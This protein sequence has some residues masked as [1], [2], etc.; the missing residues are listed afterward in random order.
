MPFQI[1]IANL[2][3]SVLYDVKY[4]VVKVCFAFSL[5][6]A[7]WPIRGEKRVP[8]NDSLWVLF[9]CCSVL[10][11]LVSWGALPLVM[12]Y[13]R[14]LCKFPFWNQS[15][16][17]SFLT[18]RQ[19]VCVMLKWAPNEKKGLDKYW[20]TWANVSNPSPR[21]VSSSSSLICPFHFGIPAAADIWQINRQLSYSWAV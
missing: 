8:T 9:F 11:S 19:N 14:L 20:L 15:K 18:H 4:H 16:R 7:F 2:Q 5:L 21:L 12:S 10:R 1:F 17:L 13:Y 6:V 3:S